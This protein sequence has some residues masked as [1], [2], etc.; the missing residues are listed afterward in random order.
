MVS[1]YL[2]GQMVR[3]SAE[4]RP[5][6]ERLGAADPDWLRQR[7]EELEKIERP[8]AS[9]GE[10]RAAEWL[11][12]RFAELGAEARIEAEPAHGTYWWPLG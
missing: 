10:R 8:S 4:Q 9:E 3:G 12:E 11:V 5:I 7:L 2:P 6:G 1:G